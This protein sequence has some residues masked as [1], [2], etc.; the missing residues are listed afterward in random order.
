MEG[1]RSGCPWDGRR[2]TDERGAVRGLDND[3]GSPGDICE[4]M[5]APGV[6]DA[7]PDVVWGGHMASPCDTSTGSGEGESGA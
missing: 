3:A 7:L 4:R 6:L 5:T 1:V 2:A